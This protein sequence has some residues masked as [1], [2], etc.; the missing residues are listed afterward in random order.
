MDSAAIEK[1]LEN[2]DPNLPSRSELIKGVRDFGVEIGTLTVLFVGYIAL[3]KLRASLSKLWDEHNRLPTAQ[4]T[5]YVLDTTTDAKRDIY[6]QLSKIGADWCALGILSNGRVSEF[7]YHFTRLTWEY[8]LDSTNHPIP[9]SVLDLKPVET[10]VK[11]FEKFCD[12]KHVGELHS[13]SGYYW[14]VTPI[15]L[16]NIIVAILVHG[17]AEKPDLSEFKPLPEKAEISAILRSMIK[18]QMGN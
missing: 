9:K 6:Y 12:V 7:G 15:C 16:N 11:L 1:I 14:L 10:S 8:K 13:G 3:Q 18:P 5:G 17:Y 2:A 4:K